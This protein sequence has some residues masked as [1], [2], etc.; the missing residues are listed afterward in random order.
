MSAFHRELAALGA[1]ESLRI[2]GEVRRVVGLIAEAEGLPLPVGSSCRIRCRMEGNRELEAE[3]LGF[4]D[5]RT[6]LVP[7]GRLDGVSPGDPVIF[8]GDRL[9]VGVSKELLGRVLDGNGEPIDGKGPAAHAERAPID[10]R[11]ISP[12]TRQRI[13]R[14]FGTGVRSIDA[15]LTAGRGQRL[16]I[17][18]GSG[19]G[20]SVL[21]GM[22][23]R[24]SDAPVTVIGLIGE[25]GREV[26]EFVERDLGDA[27]LGRSVVVVATSNESPVMRLRAARVATA[28]A[29][30]FRDQGEDVLFLLDSI[31]RVAFAQRELG[32][33]AFEPPATRAFPPSVFSLLPTL[34]ERTGPGEEGSITSFY[35]VLVEA[36]DL[37]DPIGDAVRGILDGHIWLSRRLA[38]RGHFP[39][40]DVLESVSRVMRDVIDPEHGRAAQALVED[41]ARYRDVEDLIQLGAYVRGGDPPPD[42]AVDRM[43]GIEA[44]IRQ[45]A[46]ELSS[47][48]EAREGLLAL[49]TQGQQAT[50]NPLAL[51]DGRIR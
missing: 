23:A 45:P 10:G 15:L 42:E 43:P 9:E 34:L 2:T 28:I 39:A 25:R 13:T 24:A 29:E 18:S 33:S 41:L 14:P 36:D 21:L 35:T 26:R 46:E 32:L 30:W 12:L 6:L 27:G 8:E 4:H 22:L 40:V 16:G 51:D 7:F 47:F 50:R 11:P 44:L 37:H 1:S 19:V 5:H 3:V 20:K 48:G 38:T 17:F 31:T 49:Y